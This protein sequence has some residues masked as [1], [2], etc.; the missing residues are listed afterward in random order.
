MSQLSSCYTYSFLCWLGNTG[1]SHA[2]FLCFLY[3]PPFRTFSLCEMKQ[4]PSVTLPYI[5]K[6]QPLKLAW[7]SLRITSQKSLVMPT[8]QYKCHQMACRQG[9]IFKG[10]EYIWEGKH[11]LSPTE[12]TFVLDKLLLNHCDATDSFHGTLIYSFPSNAL[13]NYYSFSLSDIRYLYLIINFKCFV[14]FCSVLMYSL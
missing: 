11:H 6:W 1:S 8:V 12:I 5:K 7:S 10:L 2:Y 13:S 9:S 4:Y 14:L 3:P